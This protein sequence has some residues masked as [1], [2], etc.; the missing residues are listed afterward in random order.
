MERQVV[1]ARPHSSASSA[2]HADAATLPADLREEQLIRL[3]LLYVL[4]VALW[5]LTLVMDAWFAPHGDRGPYRSI[6]G[7]VAAALAACTALFVRYAPVR[8]QVKVDAGTFAMV[9]HACAI[10]LLNSWTP[11]PTDVR[12]LSQ[13]TVLILF[14]GM[15]APARPWKVL[16]CG[17]VA[18]AMDPLAVWVAHVR[19]LP[20]PP[21]L[22]TFLM[23][24]ENFVCAVLAV[25][26]VRVVY[27]LAG[28]IRQARA[29]GSYHLVERLG[30]G[31]MGEVW[32]ARHRLLARD[33][34]IKLIRPEFAA[35]F[36]STQSAAARFEREAQ[37]TASLTSP[38]TIRL[39]DFG[40]T[41]DG[42]F[43]YV[44]ELLDGRDLESLVAEFG[45]LPPART[46]HLLR[47]MCASLGE[48][49][50]A[51]LIHR[52]VKPANVYVCRL[53]LEYDFVK[54]LDF[55]LVRHEDRAR[56]GTLMT[57]AGAVVGT[58]AYM[59]PEAITG[60]EVDRRAD[61]YALG[62]VTYYLLTGQPV[63]GDHGAA[64]QLAGHLQERPVPPS[65]RAA[66]P[67][68]RALDDLVMACLQ[69]DPRDR[70]QSAE[71]LADMAERVLTRDAWDAHAARRW[72]GE[73]ERDTAAPAGWPLRH[74]LT[75]VAM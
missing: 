57:H 1:I 11:Q 30:Q 19:G 66:G 61:V 65:L 53:G 22:R 26:P 45:P 60:H 43:Y 8:H 31:G 39:Y 5:V 7:G 74:G 37:A 34:A 6:V 12:P 72:W 47:Q 33:A 68:P 2:A 35:S 56:A 51:G 59:A 55:G 54:V 10:A 32:R 17:L 25:V 50:A 67:V 23:F 75:T 20:T 46:L 38:H 48:A 44:M 52:D 36:G 16:A 58:P 15:L 27:Q 70:P 9:P 62:C 21:P 28:R 41:D 3:E 71:V 40:L 49:H 18:A 14:V 42:T 24:Y 64:R 63:F 69:K 29:L 73:R 4:G 13:V